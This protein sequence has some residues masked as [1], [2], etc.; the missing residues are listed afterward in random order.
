MLLVNGPKKNPAMTPGISSCSLFMATAYL[1][2]LMLSI[3][4]DPLLL[5][6]RRIVLIPTG[7]YF[8]TH[9]LPQVLQLPVGGAAI[10]VA[11]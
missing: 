4:G 5:A 10:S 7:R 8:E 9:A 3:L 6:P 2:M 11:L 1:P